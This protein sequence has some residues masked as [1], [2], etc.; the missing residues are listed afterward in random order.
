[1]ADQDALYNSNY[2]SL[3]V[4]ALAGELTVQRTLKSVASQA[5]TYRAQVSSPSDLKVSVSSTTFTLGRNASRTL[6]ITVDGRDVPQG[7]TRF[8][9]ITF[10][11]GNRT[12]TFPVTVVRGQGPVAVDKT[13][14]PDPVVKGGTV[15]CSVTMTNT[16]TVPATV[17]L[18]DPLPK[19]LDLQRGSVVGGT[20]EGNT[21][22]FN[23]TIAA[24]QPS[25]VTVADGTGTSPAG[26][27]PLSTIPGIPPIAGVGDETIANF[28]VPE[29]KLAGTSYT[30]IGMVSDG[31]AVLGGGTQA[32]VDFINQNMPDATAPNNVIAPFWT[33]L[34]PGAGGTMRIGTLSDGV[35]TWLVLDWEAVPEFSAAATDSFEIWIGLAG[36]AVP[37]DVS[38]TYGAVGGGDGGFVSVGAENADGSR[39]STWF[40]DGAPAENAPT[41]G[42]ELRVTGTPG[43]T[44]SRVVTFDA[45]AKRVGPYVN[46]AFVT[47]N[48]FQGTAT[49]RFG[50]TVTAAP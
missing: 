45:R 26:Y 32:D 24:Q 39:G 9:S 12:F 22:R 43:V 17:S 15:S 37:E 38:M 6:S 3:Y 16:S 4:P 48:T 27:L 28:D 44:T 35:S 5:R 11:S 8:A 10:K 29:F 2:P 33:D 41:S 47:G 42:T 21:V 23:G 7:E 50:G 36:N 20:G 14:A 25:E 31:Y 1:V 46:Y 18:R 40:M 34:N 49:A 13:C 19:S 30:S